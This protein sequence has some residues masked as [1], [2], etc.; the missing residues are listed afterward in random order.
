MKNY[1]KYA[2]EIRNFDNPTFCVDFIIPKILKRSDCCG[3][4]N[5]CRLLQTMWLFEEYEEP[6]VDWSQIAV[7]TPIIVR[8]SEGEPWQRRYFAK[9]E[10]GLIYVWMHGYTSWS[11]PDGNTAPWTYA[12]LAETEK[13]E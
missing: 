4:C 7:D 9:Y 2:E 1:E 10:N 3:S 5:Q 8:D 6:E 11:T 12:K 13:G